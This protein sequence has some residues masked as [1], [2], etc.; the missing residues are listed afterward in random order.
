MGEPSNPN[1]PVA[2]DDEDDKDDENDCNDQNKY[3]C[4]MLVMPRVVMTMSV[5]R[6]TTHTHTHTTAME[7]SLGRLG[8]KKQPVYFCFELFVAQTTS[9]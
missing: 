4:D 3:E 9:Y 1:A 2:D 5:M 8:V 7:V 6:M